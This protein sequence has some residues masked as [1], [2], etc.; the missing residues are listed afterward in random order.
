[1]GNNNSL[2]KSASIVGFGTLLSR[3]LGFV[4]DVLMAKFFGT[5]AAISCF[6]VAFRIPNS[7]RDLIGEGASNA[8]FVPVFSEYISRGR[9]NE[10]WRLINLFF[11][12]SSVVLS[13]ITI[14]GIVCSPSIVRLIAPGFSKDPQ[15]LLLTVKL[16]R[17]MF[18]Y[19]LLIGL[20][21]YTIGILYSFKSFVTPAF[22]SCLLNIALIGGIFL[23]LKFF[24]M[25]L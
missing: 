19:I 12:I 2:I 6:V 18:P 10:L 25:V 14:L 24:I 8:A 17:V 21:A 4:R 16:T 23:S 3:I 11:L 9:K 13:L 5:G 20:T 1:M 22:G 15:N 7:L